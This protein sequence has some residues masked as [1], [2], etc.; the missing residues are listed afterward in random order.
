MKK[1]YNFAGIAVVLIAIAGLLWWSRRSLPQMGWYDGKMA[2]PMYGED[3]GMGYV[4]PTYEEAMPLYPTPYPETLESR[5]SSDLLIYP[6]YPS[7][8][9]SVSFSIVVSD[10]A[11]FAREF[12]SYVASIQGVTQNTSFS[13]QQRFR[14]GFL[15]VLVP[16]ARIEEVSARARELGSEVVSEDFSF[17]D[18]AGVI[19]TAQATVLEAEQVLAQK[20]VELSVATSE[21]ARARLRAEVARAQKQL[22]LAQQNLKTAERE[23]EFSMISISVADNKRHFSYDAPLSPWNQLQDAW[24]SFTYFLG[25]L[26]GGLIWLAVYSLLIVPA[27]LFAILAWKAWR[28]ERKTQS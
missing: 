26:L 20:E 23:L 4:K 10:P 2:A 12:R 3:M 16:T 18:R 5:T 24:Y 17:Y 1:T 11:Q 6:Q 21:A 28:R 25:G 9:Q 14:T 13:S 7:Y 15:T 27:V 19:E 22:L 8:Q